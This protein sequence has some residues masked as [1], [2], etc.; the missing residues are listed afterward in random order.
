MKSAC[1][2]RRATAVL[3]WTGAAPAGG[4]FAQPAASAQEVPRASLGT[5]VSR[6]EDGLGSMRG[7]RELPDGRVL[8]ADGFGEAL[9]VWTP[10][11]DA[12]TLTNVGQ[13]PEEYRMPD[14]LLPL[15][16]G[17]TLLVDLGNAR[18]TRIEADLGFGETWP[19][20]QGG[21]GAGMTMMIAEATD[22]D[23]RIY[24][25]QRLGGMM[26]VSDSA[27]IMRFDP[28]SGETA[29]AGR[30]RLPAQ[31]RRESG[32]A[33]NRNVSIRPVPFSA[34]DAWTVAWDGRV[35]I[36]RADGYRIEWIAPDGTT[37]VGTAV[38][39]D[40]VRI[41]GADQDEWLAGLGGGL[42]VE[43]TSDGGAPRISMSRSP[44]GAGDAN[45]RDF[46]WPNAKPAF[47]PNGVRTDAQGRAWVRRHVP[48]G[49][50]PLFDVFDARGERV[51][52]IELPPDRSLVAIGEAGVY[53]TRS[54][55]LDFAWLEKYPLPALGG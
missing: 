6:F 18:L 39:Y 14:G 8:I 2:G 32:D 12:D 33:N 43:A 53:L 52:Q 23:G 11:A 27:A 1:M 54:D 35:A 25:E 50:P 15:P 5:P 28:A 42:R 3:I 10:G 30:V 26:A 22:R 24:Y 36:A 20:A 48:A 41:R 19:I 45:P 29:E 55:E 44:P 4:S 31:E 34:E 17:G 51:A 13:G 46:E 37:T 16:N 7:V 38:P 40:P 21:L 49:D 47:A 9:I